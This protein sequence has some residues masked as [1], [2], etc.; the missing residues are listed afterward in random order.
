MNE[1]LPSSD[2]PT[3]S[4]RY[5]R[6]KSILDAAAGQSAADYQGYGRFWHLPLNEFLQVV[7]GADGILAAQQPSAANSERDQSAGLC[8]LWSRAHILRHA[9]RGGEVGSC[10]GGVTAAADRQAFDRADRNSVARK[11]DRDERAR[12]DAPAFAG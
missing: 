6:V 4:S 9:C 12:L 2:H 5:D 7:C 1:T 11:A 8:G 3:A 10:S